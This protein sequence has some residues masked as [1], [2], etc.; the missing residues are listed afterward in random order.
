MNEAENTQIELPDELEP[1]RDFLTQ[2]GKRTAVMAAIGLAVILAFVLYKANARRDIQEASIALAASRST[3]DLEAMM[4]NYPTTPTAPL[5]LLRLA[6]TYYSGGNYDVALAKYQEFE[7]TFPDHEMIDMAILGGTHCMEA[8][9]QI[10]EAMREFEA[11]EES[12]PGH[13]LTPIAIFGK[14]RCLEQMG[15][16]AEAKAVYED[17]IAANPK[18]GWLARAEELLDSVIKVQEETMPVAAPTE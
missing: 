10:D 11:F 5:A 9:L 13:F 6:K 7:Q 17:F 12:H 15:R 16:Y 4:A 3:Q 8:R 14:A 18:S 2:H 1:L